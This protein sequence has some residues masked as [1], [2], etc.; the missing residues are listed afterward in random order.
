MTK[1]LKMDIL[2]GPLSYLDQAPD[3]GRFTGVS[4]FCKLQG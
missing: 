1:S 4:D 2:Y 3:Q